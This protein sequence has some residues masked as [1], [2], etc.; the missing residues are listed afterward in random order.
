MGDVEVVRCA[1]PDT[2][3]IPDI[4][5]DGRNLITNMNRTAHQELRPLEITLNGASV[6]GSHGRSGGLWARLLNNMT[7]TNLGAQLS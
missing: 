3:A 4:K 1:T 7:D 6:L 2:A 5:Y